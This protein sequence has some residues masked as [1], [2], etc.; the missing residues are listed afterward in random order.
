[1]RNIYLLLAYSLFCVTVIAQKKDTALLQSFKFRTPNFRAVSIDGRAAGAMASASNANSQAFLFINP[2]LQSV[3]LISTNNRLYSNNFIVSSSFFV[4]S[5]SSAINSPP[6]NANDKVNI[7]SSILQTIEDRKYNELRYKLI[8]FAGNAQ[9]AY[10]KPQ[11]TTANKANNYSGQLS[12]SFGLGKGRIEN[13]TDA[14][15]AYNI[16]Q[17]LDESNLLAKSYSVEEAYGLAQ[18]ITQINNF[19]LFDFRRKR[20]YELKQIDAYL[21]SKGLVKENSIDYFTTVADNWFYAFNQFRRHGKEKYITLSPGINY[22]YSR[23]TSTALP[24]SYAQNTTQGGSL[25]LSVGVEKAIAK[26]IKRQFTKGASL[27]TQVAYASAN[28]NNTGLSTSGK[29]F[30]AYSF[31]NGFLQWGYFPST[32]TSVQTTLSNSLIL[33]YSD[34]AMANNTFLTLDGNYFINYKTRFFASFNLLLFTSWASS[35]DID[36]AISTSFNVGLQH[37]IR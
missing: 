10:S 29:G 13:V 5:L 21:Q 17:A 32:R 1:M 31:L 26:S 3:R 36:G 7:K 35:T 4:S 34:F 6:P 12:V 27:Q 11:G 23:I 16:L 14:Q 8:G 28:S 19:R 37:F 24:T 18:I 30:N 22:A 33:E 20:I 15:M 25:T 2:S 9:Q